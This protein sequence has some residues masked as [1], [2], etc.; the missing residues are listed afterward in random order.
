MTPAALAIV[1]DLRPVEPDE[2]VQLVLD[3]TAF[4][5]STLRSLIRAGAEVT[6]VGLDLTRVEKDL[7]FRQYEQLGFYL[8]LMNRS[9]M[10]WIGDWLIYGE[11]RY[12]DRFEQALAITGLAEST[13][14][15]RMSVCR[16]IAIPERR[17]GLSFSLHAELTALSPRDRRYW[18]DRADRNNWTRQQLRAAM[19]EKAKRDVDDTGTQTRVPGTGEVDE[20]RVV[21]AAQRIVAEKRDYG[22]DWLV[23]REAMAVLEGAL[24]VE[25]E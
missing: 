13:L 6:P 7:S 2:T 1:D 19:E 23:S 17:V 10:W 5:A 8:G 12:A 16:Q 25:E 14:L 4:G 9:C 24:G 22:T 11:G 21:E 20:K 3:E 18:L 15:N